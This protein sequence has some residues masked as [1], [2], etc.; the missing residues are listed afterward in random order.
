MDARRIV[1]YGQGFYA[2]GSLGYCAFFYTTN[3][4]A[5]QASKAQNIKQEVIKRYC[6][7]K[8]I[9]SVIANSKYPYTLAAIAKI[10]SSY[11]PQ[12]KG[13]NG[14]SFG[15][16]QIQSHIWGKFEDT[17]EGQTNKAEEILE[18]LIKEQGYYEA[19]RAYNGSGKKAKQYRNKVI[20]EVNELQQM[21]T[22]IRNS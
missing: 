14:K 12:A 8:H 9:S 18:K 6:G 3:D 11:K 19:I 2:L 4:I 20:K 13:D 17:L 15:M 22:E 5:V 16:Y 21:E 10:E 7:D 1:R